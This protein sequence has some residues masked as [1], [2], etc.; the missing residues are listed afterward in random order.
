MKLKSNALIQILS[1]FN[2]NYQ[3]NIKKYGKIMETILSEWD[4][5][6]GRKVKKVP[7]LDQG[8]NHMRWKFQ[9]GYGNYVW[10]EVF[11]E[12]RQQNQLDIKTILTIFVRCLDKDLSATRPLISGNSMRLS[13][14]F[15]NYLFD[16]GAELNNPLQIEQW[17]AKFR[18]SNK[19]AV[20]K[21]KSKLSAELKCRLGL[22][23]KL[24]SNDVP[25]NNVQIQP[26]QNLK[27]ILLNP[28]GFANSNTGFQQ[29]NQRNIMD[30]QHNIMSNQ[31]N[32][33]CDQRNITGF[34]VTNPRITPQFIRNPPYHPHESN[35]R[36]RNRRYIENR[37]R[38][39]VEVPGYIENP[40]F[41]KF[42]NVTK[43]NQMARNSIPTA[44]RVS[45][46]EVHCNQ[47]NFN[48]YPVQQ[49]PVQF[50]KGPI[51]FDANPDNNP[52][53]FNFDP[54]TYER[55]PSPG[56]AQSLFEDT[57]IMD[58]CTLNSVFAEEPQNLN[59]TLQLPEPKMIY[60][61]VDAPD[62][63]LISVP[64]IPDTVKR[65]NSPMQ[66]LQLEVK[67]NTSH[68]QSSN[69][70]H[71]SMGAVS[72]NQ[73]SNAS[74]DIS[75]GNDANTEFYAEPLTPIM[76][77]YHEMDCLFKNSEFEP[78]GPNG[79]TCSSFIPG[80]HFDSMDFADL[81]TGLR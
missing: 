80:V 35:N 59:D 6:I 41:R 28:R 58:E 17:R 49:F 34:Q 74:T 52:F 12:I 68:N 57:I 33:S 70:S 61:Q 51:Q 18:N 2:I 46:S 31:Q 50:P 30:N 11:T 79:C 44:K 76:H 48:Y 29:N 26:P 20:S 13:V 73:S 69:T 64:E 39:V 16:L 23:P 62:D 77:A 75:L 47:F 37:N 15:R 24:P 63:S 43:F 3:L 8:R 40:Q 7:N 66:Q 9:R 5:Y 27:R 36:N 71:N 54:S 45:I 60:P 19:N 67:Q 25:S 56:P 53:N 38:N 78:L 32:I 42:K 81:S 72:Y 65:V 22:A 21:F 55:P 10:P 14:K 1:E 4:G